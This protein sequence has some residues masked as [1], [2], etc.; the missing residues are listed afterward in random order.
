VVVVD[1]HE[2]E[3]YKKAII[4]YH[5]INNGG[6]KLQLQTVVFSD[7]FIMPAPDKNSISPSIL[8]RNPSSVAAANIR[9][10]ATIKKR[11]NTVDYGKLTERFETEFDEANQC[12]EVL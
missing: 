1:I 9:M 4:D 10:R 5:V 2:W 8:L 6:K 12:E 3:D 11:K 7:A